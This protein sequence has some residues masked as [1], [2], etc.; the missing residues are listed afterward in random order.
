VRASRSRLFFSSVLQRWL[1]ERVVNG[2]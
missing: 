2:Q 1:L